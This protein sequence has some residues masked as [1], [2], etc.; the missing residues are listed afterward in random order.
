MLANQFA[1]ILDHL[2]LIFWLEGCRRND[3]AEIVQSAVNRLV[4]ADSAERL[5]KALRSESR[6]LRR[7][8]YRAAINAGI[9]DPARII[10]LGLSSDDGVLRLWATRDAKTLLPDSELDDVLPS[11]LADSFLPVRREALNNLMERFPNR[12]NEAL[13]AALLDS[14]YSMREF[15]RFYLRKSVEVDF[16]DYYRTKLNKSDSQLQAIAGLGE[17]GNADDERL[18]IPFLADRRSSIRAAAVRSIG[19]LSKGRSTTTLLRATKDTSKKVTTEACIAI[20]R[21]IDEF[22]LPE[23]I[24]I[25][26]TEV[27]THVLLA[28]LDL[29]D[30]KG[31]WATMPH[32]IEAA[33]SNNVDVARAAKAK[34]CSKFN[35]VFTNPTCEQ[36]DAVQSALKQNANSI[37]VE[38]ATEFRKWLASRS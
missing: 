16:G 12:A 35:R 5:E 33:V 6:F 24:A 2:D 36:R 14:G 10:R 27:R 11:L 17:S 19:L 18:L 34:I 13:T 28:I 9:S 30:L 21:S 32:L 23:L 4:S 26:R 8:T 15:A 31:T 20:E 29:I 1:P 7:R 25:L 37:S 22:E 3:Q 38:F